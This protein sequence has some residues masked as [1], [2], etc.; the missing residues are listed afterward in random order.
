MSKTQ[1]EYGSAGRNKITWVARFEDLLLKHDGNVPQKELQAFAGRIIGERV[2]KA[3]ADIHAIATPL[4]GGTG[5]KGKTYHL[6]A[7]TD[8][9]CDW[10][11]SQV[12]ESLTALLDGLRAGKKT[13]SKSS[14][15]AP[16]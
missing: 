7:A 11:E 12:Q 2:E 13:A 8:T 14:I 6:P 1:R 16:F 4:L 5:Y 15:V 3:K 10:I 9:L